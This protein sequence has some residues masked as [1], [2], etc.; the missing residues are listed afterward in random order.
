MARLPVPLSTYQAMVDQ[1]LSE[2]GDPQ[3]SRERRYVRKRQAARDAALLSLAYT[4]GASVSELIDLKIG[5]WNLGSGPFDQASVTLPDRR[6]RSKT[7]PLVG[8]TRTLQRLWEHHHRHSSFPS[9]SVF[10]PIS[11]RGVIY[12]QQL[13]QRGIHEIITTRYKQIRNREPAPEPPNA[14][15]MRASFKQFLKSEGVKDSIVRDLMDLRSRR[16]A[17]RDDQ[18]A[19]GKMR[20]ALWTIASTASPNKRIPSPPGSQL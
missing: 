18:K 6:P 10:H 4:C 19:D 2:V 13:T 5:Q 11:K 20:D 3:G 9:S 12:K 7:L 16:T 8:P 15:R 1:C 14:Q 17:P